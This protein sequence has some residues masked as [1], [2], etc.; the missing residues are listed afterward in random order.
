MNM[1]NERLSGITIS[2]KTSIM[3]TVN[4]NR[5]YDTM[6]SIDFPLAIFAPMI[7]GCVFTGMFIF[8]SS[9]DS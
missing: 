3:K 1:I 9:G 4:H 2:V 5:I 6:A 7:K 8:Q